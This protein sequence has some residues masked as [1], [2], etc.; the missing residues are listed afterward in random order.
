MENIRK[1]ERSCVLIKKKQRRFLIILVS[2]CTWL[3]G[4]GKWDIC[5]IF[6]LSAQCHIWLHAL[7]TASHP[8]PSL[9][10][11]SFQKPFLMAI[12][13][14]N[15]KAFRPRSI[16]LQYYISYHS[17]ISYCLDRCRIQTHSVIKKLVG[18][19]LLIE[20][21]KWYISSLTFQRWCMHV[22]L[23]TY[24]VTGCYKW[25]TPTQSLSVLPSPF[26]FQ[27]IK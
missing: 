26:Y 7:I 20:Q 21:C 5:S 3:K 1:I 25:V 6:F 15:H 8:N 14:M 12:H 22:V 9:N 24:G 10:V 17:Y 27:I 18:H 13:T 4:L 16:S 2:Q 23:A 11:N 19:I